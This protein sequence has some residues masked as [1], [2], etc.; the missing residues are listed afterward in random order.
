MAGAPH[1][2]AAHARQVAP[3]AL[4][5]D[6]RGQGPGAAGAQ[7]QPS[8]SYSQ[9]LAPWGRS[10]AGGPPWGASSKA[11]AAKGLQPGGSCSQEAAMAAGQHAVGYSPDDGTLAVAARLVM[12]WLC[13]KQAVRA[14][15]T[16]RA[17][18][19]AFDDVSWDKVE[20]S[21]QHYVQV[22]WG[23]GPGRPSACLKQACAS[24]VW[25]P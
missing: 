11:T 12:P 2:G 13:L 21:V 6:S 16:C 24:G 3:L 1:G 4:L 10:V 20:M 8:G 23:S 25:P 17:F 15:C 18:R 22:G 14:R 19:A 7:L 5:E 9:D